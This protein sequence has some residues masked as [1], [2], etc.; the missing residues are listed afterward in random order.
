M[1]K[2]V[3]N[4]DKTTLI[5]NFHKLIIS[6]AGYEVGTHNYYGFEPETNVYRWEVNGVEFPP[7]I[8][9]PVSVDWSGE[10]RAKDRDEMRRKLIEKY[11][12]LGFQVRF[13]R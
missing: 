5:I 8:S 10:D 13:K 12:S 1:E 4:T 11:T 2:K 3:A 9:S 6:K 7:S